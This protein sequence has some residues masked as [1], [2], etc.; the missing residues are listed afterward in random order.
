MPLENKK[1]SLFQIIPKIP[2]EN[3][4]QKIKMKKQDNQ[5]S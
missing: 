5:N 3:K 2:E 4:Y 1:K